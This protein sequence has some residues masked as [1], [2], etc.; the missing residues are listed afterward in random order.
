M[1]S[2]QQII[3]QFIN[4][5]KVCCYLTMHNIAYTC[6]QETF[7]LI[8]NY[9]PYIHAYMAGVMYSRWRWFKLGENWSVCETERL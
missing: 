1:E 2:A 8:H 3:L 6:I 4:L 5:E 7:H 9:G